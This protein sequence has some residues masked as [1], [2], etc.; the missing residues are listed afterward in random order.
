MGNCTGASGSRVMDIASASP[1]KTLKLMPTICSPHLVKRGSLVSTGH[2]FGRFS[3]QPDFKRFLRQY[4]FIQQVAMRLAGALARKPLSLVFV[5]VKQ[6]ANPATPRA[7]RLVALGTADQFGRRAFGVDG[8][9][10]LE[11]VFKIKSS[12]RSSVVRL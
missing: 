5:V 4:R 1:G 10:A 2:Q 12:M 9:P 3:G 7:A 11:A 8:R 6:S